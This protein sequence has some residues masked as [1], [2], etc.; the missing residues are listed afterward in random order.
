MRTFLD[1]LS[2]RNTEEAAALLVQVR[3]RGNELREPRSKK[4]EGVDDLF[5]L[6]GHQVRMFY[7]FRPGRV[8]VLLDG[9]IKKQDRIARGD[10]DRVLGYLRL[11][12]QRGARAP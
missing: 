11:V 1:G 8:I 5:E 10:L 12:L 3:A 7:T 6:R 2:G 4:V 9:V